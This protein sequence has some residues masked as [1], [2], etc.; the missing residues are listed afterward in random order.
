MIPDRQ[1][2]SL[3]N[4]IIYN[5]QGLIV[6]VDASNFILIHDL[7]SHLFTR[8]ESDWLQTIPKVS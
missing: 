5:P 6:T 2:E 4:Y 7:R 8:M 3:T 1:V